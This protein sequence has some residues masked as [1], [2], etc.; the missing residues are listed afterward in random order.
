MDAVYVKIYRENKIIFNNNFLGNDA[1]NSEV[2]IYNFKTN[3]WETSSDTKRVGDL[4]TPRANLGCTLY[5][6]AAC[7]FGGYNQNGVVVDVVDCLDLE[8]G[9]WTSM[10]PL[11]QPLSEVRPVSRND[12][13]WILGGMDRTYND[14]SKVYRLR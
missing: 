10:P 3:T 4:P 12:G 6:Q 7:C 2:V 1:K 5:A 8:S 13:I 11:P 14:V 9:I